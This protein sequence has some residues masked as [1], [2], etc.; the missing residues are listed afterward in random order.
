MRPEL[1]QQQSI[2]LPQGWH[3][4]MSAVLRDG[5]HQVL[6]LEAMA[7]QFAQSCRARTQ[8]RLGCGGGPA[9]KLCEELGV[10]AI[11]FGPHR[12]GFGKMPHA[13][14]FDDRHWD[15]RGL[16]SGDDVAF[17]TTGGFAHDE[18]RSG[19]GLEA[20]Q[21]FSVAH[22][23]IGQREVLVVEVYLEGVFA[24]IQADIDS[25]GVRA[26]PCHASKR[27]QRLN[28]RFELTDI[29]PGD[30]AT[31]VRVETELGT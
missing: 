12:A 22:W 21:Q 23:R 26:H 7:N 11:G 6:Q 27:L 9:A 17:E 24:N 2:L 8:G 14:W 16:A 20:G 4:K 10:D 29:E 19:Q 1:A 31:F 25:R 3:S 28:Q 18:Q 30:R 15:G 5:L 13:G